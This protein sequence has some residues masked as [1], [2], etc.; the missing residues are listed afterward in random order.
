[1]K[2]PDYLSYERYK[3][4]KDS[5]PNKRMFTFVLTFFVT[6]MFFSLVAKILSPDVD[7]TIGSDTE[8]DAKESG[9]GVKRFIDNRLKMI[10][11]DDNSSG[12]QKAAEKVSEKTA[13]QDADPAYTEETINIPKSHNE[14][15]VMPD[16]ATPP[17]PSTKDLSTPYE[18]PKVS[19][20]YV[21]RYATL[22]QA[23]VAQD[24]LMDAGVGVTPFIKDLG[25]HYTLQ[26][27]SYSS[28]AKAEEIA[29]ELRRNNFPTKVVQE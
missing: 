21:G 25:G 8:L 19:K 26:I 27:G 13:V 24:I 16:Y 22:E 23:K 17:R 20:V 4:K 28:R 5:K 9:L 10:Q 15:D 18:S 1:M 12:A 14:Q 29:S 3:T 11:M 6:L 2:T 7:V